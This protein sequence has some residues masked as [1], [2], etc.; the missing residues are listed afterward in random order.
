MTKICKTCKKELDISCYNNHK[1]TRDGKCHECKKCQCERTRKNYRKNREEKLIYAKEYNKN[2]QEEIKVY[3]KKYYQEN[4]E[5]LNKI[6]QEYN[7]LHEQET[8][9]YHREYSYN[10]NLEH[11][12]EK[13]IYRKQWNIDHPGYYRERQRINRAKRIEDVRKKAREYVRMRSATDSVFRLKKDL[14]KREARALKGISKSASTMELLGCD[15]EFCMMY[16]QF[17]AYFNG[18]EDFDINDYD[19]KLYHKDHI[20]PVSAFNLEC[21][22]HQKL[23]FHWSNLQILSAEDNRIKQDKIDFNLT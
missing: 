22:Y 17:T 11:Q 20:I 13:A 19:S 1:E 9:E 3:K 10:Y 12:E 7:K 5:E 18:Y 2:H 8:K 23:C 6:H 14:R 15:A 4:K 16:L 21:S